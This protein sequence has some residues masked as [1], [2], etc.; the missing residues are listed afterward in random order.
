MGFTKFAGTDFE[1]Y[2]IPIIPV[3]AKLSPK[4]TLAQDRLGKI[5]GKRYGDEGWG[6]FLEDAT[7]AG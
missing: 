5:P 7:M 4:S 3:G 2:V 6:R 1:K